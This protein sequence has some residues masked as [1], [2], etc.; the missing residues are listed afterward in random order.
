MCTSGNCDGGGI[1]AI[2][3]EMPTPIQPATY[4]LVSITGAI[5][6]LAVVGGL[7]R[8]H[9]AQRRKRRTVLDEQWREQLE[10]RKAILNLHA[11]AAAESERGSRSGS[12][13][14][15][16]TDK[17]DDGCSEYTRGTTSGS[18]GTSEGGSG[19]RERHASA[20]TRCS[21]DRFVRGVH[22]NGSIGG[23]KYVL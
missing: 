16:E 22:R 20:S 5:S 17:G 3:S 15:T 11:V 8:F 2:P 14:T 13:T 6:M 7:Y 19:R 21:H 12:D 10:F 4:A 18:S 1:C 9:Q 23:I